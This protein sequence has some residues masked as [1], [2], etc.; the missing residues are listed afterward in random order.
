MAIVWKQKPFE[1]LEHWVKTIY[2]DGID[3]N[4]WET[5]F[6]EDMTV[7]VANKWPL[8]EAQERK[9]ENIYAEK[10]PTK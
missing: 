2:M 9:L 1:V 6:L 3:L 7:K 10:T 4:E 8:T 5:T